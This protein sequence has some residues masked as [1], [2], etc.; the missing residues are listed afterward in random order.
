MIEVTSRGHWN[1]IS[2]A[3]P[4]QR[5]L[6]DAELCRRPYHRLAPDEIA[7]FCSGDF[8]PPARAAEA[9]L[10]IL[11][12]PSDTVLLLERLGG[13]GFHPQ[14]K[15]LKPAAVRI[16]KWG[17]LLLQPVHPGLK[18]FGVEG[19]E[20]Q[21]CRGRPGKMARNVAGTL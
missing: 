19:I 7:D 9:K 16:G 18:L 4:A 21:V 3:D 20:G 10:P 14:P 5:E 15:A 6:G 17:T 8:D 12:R 13:L 2:L 1:Q 11:A